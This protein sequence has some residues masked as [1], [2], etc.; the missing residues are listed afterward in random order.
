MEVSQKT[1]NGTITWPRNSTHGIYLKK[2]K[3]TNLKKYINPSVALLIIVKTHT[4]T[5]RDIHTMDCY[6]V[7][8]NN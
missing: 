6:S 3:H 8:K 5:H 7:I 4:H 2:K 1:E